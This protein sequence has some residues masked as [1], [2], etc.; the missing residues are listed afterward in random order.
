MFSYTEALSE[1]ILKELDI[2]SSDI[3]KI[4]PIF[5]DVDFIIYTKDKSYNIEIVDEEKDYSND[6]NEIITDEFIYTKQNIEI[7]DNLIQSILSFFKD[8]KNILDF[9]IKNIN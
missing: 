6:F 1:T 7:L 8:D 4:E 5:K 9:D 2:E 3:I